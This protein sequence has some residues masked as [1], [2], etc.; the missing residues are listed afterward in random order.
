M[1]RVYTP[2]GGGSG[3]CVYA[4]NGE[5][6]FLTARHLYNER[7]R[8]VQRMVNVKA[9]ITM[10]DG[11]VFQVH[12][13]VEHPKA[14]LC[15]MFFSYSGQAPPYVGIDGNTPVQKTKVWKVGYPAL[16]NRTAPLDTRTGYINGMD[17]MGLAFTNYIRPGDSGGGLFTE[18]GQ[19]VG[20]LIIAE[21]TMP[22]VGAKSQYVQ[23]I[24]VPPRTVYDFAHTV[25][26]PRLRGRGPNP[27]RMQPPP[28]Q[29]PQTPAPRIDS[30]PVPTPPPNPQPG[31]S[32]DY[33]PILK[34]MLETNKKILDRIE[35]LEAQKATPGPKGD[36]GD[37]GKDGKCGP[38]GPKGETGVP[39][40]MGPQGPEGRAG[41]P[42]P[43]GEPGTPADNMRI[44][45]LEKELII[46]KQ[47]IETIQ[48]QP[49]QRVRVVPAEKKP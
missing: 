30:P 32:P 45:A 48:V 27:G 33:G 19:L 3:V 20:I 6:V 36:K 23:G 1:G 49:E 18:K 25:C 34:D 11:R 37:P 12:E 22:Y 46:L 39:G 44:I 29:E 13:T 35:R 17:R 26:F 21:G 47:R 16:P 8:S 4:G 42:G 41:P 5:G 31:P 38:A 15:A 10:K 40:A 43:K 9:N 28:P 7:F 2:K 14:D 24:A